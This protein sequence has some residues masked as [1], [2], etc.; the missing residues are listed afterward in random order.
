LRDR[1]AE[2]LVNTVSDRLAERDTETLGETLRNVEAKALFYT[3]ADT[4]T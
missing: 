2:E 4:V 3:L 1:E